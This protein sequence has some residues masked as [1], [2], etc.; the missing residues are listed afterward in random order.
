MIAYIDASVLLRVVLAQP[1]RL[2]AWSEI[3]RGVSSRLL[4]VECLRTLD[5]LRL[6]GSLDDDAL[7]ATRASVY[8]LLDSIDLVEITQPVLTRAAAPYPTVLAG[9]AA[10]HLATALLW[11]QG[12]QTPTPLTVVTHDHALAR[13]ARACGLRAVGD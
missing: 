10:I 2:D 11:N 4:E 5:R 13:A 8:A 3:Q 1:D 7:A 6:A 9:L 12:S